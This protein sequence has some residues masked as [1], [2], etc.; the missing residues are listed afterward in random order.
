M[1]EIDPSCTITLMILIGFTAASADSIK[2][3][4]PELLYTEDE[5]PIRYDGTLTTLR[6]YGNTMYF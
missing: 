2:V 1:K 5:I 4:K 3:G 6:K